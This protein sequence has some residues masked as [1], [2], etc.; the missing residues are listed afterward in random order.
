MPHLFDGQ[1]DER[2]SPSAIEPTSRFRPRYRALTDQEKAT[3]DAIKA[4]A[5]M[6]ETLY[7][8]IEPHDRYHALAMTS[9][10]ESVMWA[11]KSLTASA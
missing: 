8:K 6:L 9:L 7:D 11:I 10:E 1:P 4:A 2:Q 5:V 3:H